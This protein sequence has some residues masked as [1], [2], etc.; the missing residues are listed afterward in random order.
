M[1]C[2]NTVLADT[3]NAIAE[4]NLQIIVLCYVLKCIL[5]FKH[6]QFGT[7]EFDVFSRPTE[8]LDLFKILFFSNKQ[9][10]ILLY[11]TAR[12]ATMKMVLY[13]PLV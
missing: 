6:R 11:Q 3:A 5:S 4:H 10:W 13:L 2:G 12:Q 8:F 7:I 9:E 1:C